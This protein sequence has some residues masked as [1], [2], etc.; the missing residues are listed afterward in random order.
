MSQLFCL[1]LQFL[2]Y[3]SNCHANIK[4]TL[5]FEENSTIPFL[6]ILIKRHNHTFSTSIYRKKTFT[7]LYTKWDSFTPSKYKLNQSSAHS[8][9]MVSASVRHLLIWR[10]SLNE[11]RKLSLQSGLWCYQL[12][13]IH[14][15]LNRQQNRPRNPTTTVPKK[16]AILV[17]PYVE[18]LFSISGV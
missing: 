2:Y 16:E 10:S 17:L 14:D 12:L 1:G 8:L 9:F 18:V 4:F 6:D 5:K 15:V 3:F 11:Q 13:N 7:G